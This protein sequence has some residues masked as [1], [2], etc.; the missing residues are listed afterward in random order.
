MSKTTQVDPF[1]M[2]DKLSRNDLCFCGSGKKL[3]HCCIRKYDALRDF[4]RS[5][6][7]KNKKT[8]EQNSTVAG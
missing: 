5:K 6:S 7:I 8:D 4:Y 1:S 3:K 2:P